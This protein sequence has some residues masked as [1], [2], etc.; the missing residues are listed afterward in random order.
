[1]PDFF[2]VF[3]Y[4]VFGV[5]FGFVYLEHERQQ[6]KASKN[7]VRNPTFIRPNPY[8]WKL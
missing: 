6:A 1:V 4:F 8:L 7:D 3:M 2:C 5:G